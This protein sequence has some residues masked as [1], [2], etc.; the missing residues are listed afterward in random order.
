[1]KKTYIAPH[2]ETI[3]NVLQPLLEG[4]VTSPYGIGWGGVDT[5]GTQVPGSRHRNQ[6]WDDDDDDFDF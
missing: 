6:L 1:M 5:N 4:S 3:I 2:T